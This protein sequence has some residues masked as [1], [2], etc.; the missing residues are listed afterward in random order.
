MQKTLLC[1]LLFM[2]SMLP[3]TIFAGEKIR[4][5]FI[6]RSMGSDYWNAVR[7][8]ALSVARHH[9]EIDLA[10]VGPAERDDIDE[11]MRIIE[12]ELDAGSR[13]MIIA[14]CDEKR[15]L[16]TLDKVHERGVKVIMYDSASSWPHKT[17]SIGSNNV[18]GGYLAADHIASRLGGKG[19]VAVITGR[20]ATSPALARVNGARE[21]WRI[22]REIRLVAVR[23]ADWDTDK[24]YR[25]ALDLL[26]EH[27]DLAAFFCCNDDMAMGALRAVGESGSGAFVVG[28]DA[29][30]RALRS[31]LEGG[32]AAT[33]A[34][35]SYNIGRLAVRAAYRAAT[36]RKI[37]SFIDTGMQL[38]TPDNVDQFLIG[39]K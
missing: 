38:V 13:I 39:A 2:M 17:G 12:S 14:P 21:A 27:P 7:E 16:D 20:L 9:P 19:K 23:S 26:R 30:P 36:D 32:L 6:P 31:I 22:R 11:Q 15:I 5:S 24:A 25:E 18:L 4:I 28:F 35:N 37:P 34:Q 33:V 8:G 29:T 3:G 1:L 10:F